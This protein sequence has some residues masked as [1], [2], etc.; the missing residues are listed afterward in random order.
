MG[1]VIGGGALLSMLLGLSRGGM[2]VVGPMLPP[3]LAGGLPA[4][5]ARRCVQLLAEVAL[6]STREWARRS[7]EEE[8]LDERLGRVRDLYARGGSRGNN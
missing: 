4:A 7:L 5:L 6:E 8:K 2:S 3:V 1:P